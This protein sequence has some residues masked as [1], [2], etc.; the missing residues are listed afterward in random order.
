MDRWHQLFLLHQSKIPNPGQRV[1]ASPPECCVD[2]HE[3]DRLLGFGLHYRASQFRL[4]K[5][6]LMENRI[7]KGELSERRICCQNHG[8]QYLVTL[9]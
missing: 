7:I 5:T 3:S 6:K 1:A 9:C 8:A 4:F 2:H